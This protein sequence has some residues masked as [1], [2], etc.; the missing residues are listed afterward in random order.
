M[1]TPPFYSEIPDT[2]GPFRVLRLLGVGGM[3]AVFLGERMEQF[4]QQVAIKILHPDLFPKAADAKIAKE[5]Q[6]LAALDHPGIVRMLDLGVSENGSRYIV[7][8]YV[9]GVPLDIYCENQHLPLRRRIEILLEVMDA[10]EYAHRH[11]VVHADLKP[12]NIL[13]SLEGKPRLLDFGVATVL[14]DMGALEV[15]TAKIQPP[16]DVKDGGEFASHTALYGSPEQRSG[17][18]LSAASDVYSLG[19]ISESVLAGVEPEILSPN[20][21]QS[22]FPGPTP[23][24]ASRKL[25]LLDPEKFARIAAARATTSGGLEAAIHGDLE[26]I[27]SKAT[28]I[29]PKERFQSVQEMR[30]E[31]E[32]HLLGYPIQTRPIG[33][34]VRG[35]KMALRNRLAAIVGFVFILVVLFSVLGI[36]KKANEAARKRQIAQDRLHEL[37]RLTDVLAGDLYHSLD[38]LE[39]AEPAQSALLNSAHQTMNQL[40]SDDEQDAQLE[41]ELA[42]EYEKLARLELTR[43][44]LGQRAIQQAADDLDKER[45][46]LD[47]LNHR[48][49]NVVQLRARLPQMVQ[50]LTA[51]KDQVNH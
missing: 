47:L 25:R 8:E 17:E 29:D 24:P 37:V 34:L 26:A 39:G 30:D 6:L 48:D 16:D 13:V 51:A 2:I 44:R 35:Y 21:L 46:L 40:A 45:A 41:L 49:P 28:R 4:S 32:R 42:G 19:L 31:F 9:D 36:V 22:N 43:S 33:W 50:L 14:S 10:V 15:R 5:G 27:I 11:L 23:L 1:Q 7:M 20:V 18:R 38:G 12:E 3:G